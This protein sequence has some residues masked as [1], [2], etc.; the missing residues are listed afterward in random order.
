MPTRAPI[1]T[2]RLCA[3]SLADRLAE[4]VASTCRRVARSMSWALSSEA[5]AA[6]TVLP[7]SSLFSVAICWLRVAWRWARVW[8]ATV[9]SIR[10]STWPGWTR[11]PTL[12][13]TCLTVPPSAN[14]RLCRP[15]GAMEPDADTARATVPRSTVTVGGPGSSLPV[16]LTATTEIATMRITAI[17]TSRSLR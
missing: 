1:L 12:T 17:A 10:A 16:Q 8:R 6:S 11:S 3:T 7:P 14:P 9:S 2:G 5:C 15:D 13:S 4:F